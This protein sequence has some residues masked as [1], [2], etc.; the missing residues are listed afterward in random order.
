MSDIAKQTV[1][2]AIIVHPDFPRASQYDP[3]WVFE[4]GMGWP[5]LWATEALAEQ[6]ELKPGMRVLD[7]GCG[8]ASSSIFLAREYGVQVWAGELWISPSENAVRIE[9]QEVDHLVFPLRAD[10]NALPFAENYFDAIV[11]F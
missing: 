3:E 11:S 1:P 7:L 10:A 4:T 8:K 9:E 2:A 5:V 6:M